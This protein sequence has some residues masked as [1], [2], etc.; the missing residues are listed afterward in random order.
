MIDFLLDLIAPVKCVFCSSPKTLLCESHILEPV[1]HE[2]KLDGITGF[3]A[4]ELDSAMLAALSAFKDRS[5][6][7]LAPV[8]AKSIEPL[9]DSASWQGATRVAV[10]PSSPKAYRSRGFVPV[11]QILRHSKNSLPVVSLGLAR[12]VKDQRE[13][14]AR[15]RQL[16][17]RG[18]F[19]APMLTG[20][21]VVL[22]DDVLTT[23][24]TIQEMRRAIEVAGGEV[25]GFCV[26]AR[27]FVHSTQE[28]EIKA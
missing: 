25:T 18:A 17:L 24:A 16:N 2:E 5:M 3:Y 12:K 4:T 20:E 6:T 7:A 10:P 9:V 1:A 28:L 8:F 23:S 14:D 27:R 19:R 21:R 15:A 26:L 22:F 11:K 13:L